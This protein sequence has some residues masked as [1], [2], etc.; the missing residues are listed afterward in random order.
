MV[1]LN[2]DYA[3]IIKKNGSIPQLND[4]ELKAEVEKHS[5]MLD[6]KFKKLNEQWAKHLQDSIN[7]VREDSIKT[8]KEYE[9][10]LAAANKNQK[11]IAKHITTIESRLIMFPCRVH[12]VM[13]LYLKILYIQ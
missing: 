1:T 5:K 12:F 8:A 11:L 3:K 13:N 9:A 6:T 2:K 10:M 4:E 7:R